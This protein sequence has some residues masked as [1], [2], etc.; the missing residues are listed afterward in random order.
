MRPLAVYHVPRPLSVGNRDVVLS[1]VDFILC[2]GGDGTILY[3]ASLFQEA[4]P[5]MMSFHVGSLGFLTHFVYENYQQDIRRVIEGNVSLTLRHRLQCV[6]KTDY[7]VVETVEDACPVSPPA[8]SDSMNGG[9]TMLF[10]ATPK[11]FSSTSAD[12]DSVQLVMNELVVDRGP[13]P[14]L[15]NLELYCNGRFMTSVQ[16]DGIIISTPTGST[17]YSLAAGA[18]MVHPSV[19]CMV[20]TPI[21]PHSLSFRP[22]VLPAGVEMTVRVAANSR[23]SAWAAYDG[24]NRREVKQGDSVVV[25]TSACP[26]PTINNT[27]HV[28]DWFDSLAECLH[29]NVRKQQKQLAKVS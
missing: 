13:H 2:I 14:Y 12:P 4:I 20:I 3:T 23:N 5:P 19:S 28:T 8:Q 6:F 11:L 1:R 22:T 24:R 9:T 7:E 29:W 18:S 21:C 26:V 25:T 15:C 16:G 27:G 10:N 17:A